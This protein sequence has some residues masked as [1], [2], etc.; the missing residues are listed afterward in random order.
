[1]ANIDIRTA[2]MQS[3]KKQ[4]E[5]ANKLGIQDSSLS[6]LLRA[7]L[8]PEKKSEILKAIEELK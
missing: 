2:I 7:E 8:T 1:M 6:R 4:W 3:G 5:I